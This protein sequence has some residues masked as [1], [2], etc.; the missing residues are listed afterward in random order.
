M[1]L[2]AFVAA[3][4]HADGQLHHAAALV[5][6][7]IGATSMRFTPATLAA[8]RD[9]DNAPAARAVPA[10]LPTELLREVLVVYA[11]LASRTGAF[12]GVRIYGSPGRELPIGGPDAKQVPGDLI[13]QALEAIPAAA[14]RACPASDPALPAARLT[15]RHLPFLCRPP[16]QLAAHLRRLAL[17]GAS[18]H[19]AQVLVKSFK[20][21][22]T[23]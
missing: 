8:I 1:Q 6:G 4:E 3:A 23:R 12:G 11:D 16:G 13:C 22:R 19:L 7:D 14:A 18:A 15:F 20:L 17:A 9:L 21:A 5:N 10:G 2:A